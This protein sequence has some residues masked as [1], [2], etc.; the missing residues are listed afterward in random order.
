[1]RILFLIF[2][3]GIVSKALCQ[4][5]IDVIYLKTG[6]RIECTIEAVSADTLVF[7][8]FSGRQKVVEKIPF[9][10]VVT[11]I[12]N[13]HYSTPGEDLIK[14]SGHFYTGTTFMVVGGI[15]TVLAVNARNKDL[16]IAG[17]AI[18]MFGSVFLYS[19]FSKLN[20]AARKFRKIE[21]QSDRIIFKL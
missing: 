13:N 15:T 7:S 4:K 5:N 8:R 14:A 2:I 6:E 3:L 10:Q 11:Y 1:M 18:G 12:V 19:G 17:T 20:Q 21:L 9:N 16:A